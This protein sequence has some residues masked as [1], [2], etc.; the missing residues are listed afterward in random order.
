MSTY[1]AYFPKYSKIRKI[2]RILFA[3]GNHVWYNRF[4][5]IV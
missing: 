5:Q 4:I 1:A 3:F 2:F